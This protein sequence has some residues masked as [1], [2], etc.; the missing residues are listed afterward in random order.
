MVRNLS[1]LLVLFSHLLFYPNP[2]YSED[3][4]VIAEEIFS[5]IN[6]PFCP[7]R[8]LKDCPSNAAMELKQSIIDRANAGEK[9]ERIMNQLY[10][11]HGEILR[12]TPDD[13][14]MGSVAWAG[15]FVFLGVGAIV[16]FLF[17]R[18]QKKTTI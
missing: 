18:T 11:E 15:P 1:I 12:A 8:L 13:S 9:K 7:G 2:G 16:L 17:M 3:G 4:R 6:S 10:K 5:E 14:F